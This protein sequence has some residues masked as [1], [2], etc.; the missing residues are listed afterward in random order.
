MQ[1]EFKVIRLE[2]Q[3]IHVNYSYML[4]EMPV[5]SIVPHLVERRL[6]SPTQA[7]SVNDLG[8]RLEKVSAL[9]QALRGNN[10]VGRLP[11]FCAALISAGLSHIAERLSKSKWQWASVVLLL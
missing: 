10:V 1:N 4:E 9:L 5:D 3:A 8:S 7:K 2:W 6:L 11:T